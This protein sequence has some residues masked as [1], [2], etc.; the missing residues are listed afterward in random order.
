VR[1]NQ[2]PD[3]FKLA[4]AGTYGEFIQKGNYTYTYYGSGLSNGTVQY[5]LITGRDEQDIRDKAKMIVGNAGTKIALN[6]STMPLVLQTELKAVETCITNLGDVLTTLEASK[7]GASP[8]VTDAVYNAIS[9]IK[10]SNDVLST[11][12]AAISTE[13]ANIPP[14]PSA[15]FG[16]G[17][18]SRRAR[19]KNS[20]NTRKKLRR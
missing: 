3:G 17:R 11:E 8:N 1:P 14:A 4:T 19:R 16:G 2:I 15:P 10:Q 13:M 6:E 12:G 5:Y 9:R 20:K 18:R 7:K